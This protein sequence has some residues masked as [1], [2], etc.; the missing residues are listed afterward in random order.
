MDAHWRLCRCMAHSLNLA[1]KHVLEAFAPTPPHILAKGRDSRA[2]KPAD[3]DQGDE[4][5]E[6]DEN[7]LVDFQ[8]GD[9]LGKTHA[10]VTQACLPFDDSCHGVSDRSHLQVRLSPQARAFFSKQCGAANVPRLELLKWC[11][12]RWSSMDNMIERLIEL[13]PVCATILLLVEHFNQPILCSRR[14][15]PSSFLRMTA[16]KSPNSRMAVNTRSLR[17][18]MQNGNS[19]G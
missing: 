11:R 15:K 17:Y 12:T 7:E 10:F 14:S 16:T 18:R 3:V 6:L 19:W 9:L 13:R 8:P 1:A 4:E 5:G 2:A